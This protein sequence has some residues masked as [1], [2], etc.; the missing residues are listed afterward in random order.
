MPP[1]AKF[2][3]SQLPAIPFLATN[4]VTARGVSA[5]NVVA[6]IDMPARYQG[7]FLPDRKNSFVSLPARF[8]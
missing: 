4:S 3:Q 2:H 7:R 6:T 8:E 5:A 1:N